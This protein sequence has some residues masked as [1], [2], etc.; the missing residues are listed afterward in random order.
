[1]TSTI[2]VDN[3]QDQDGNNIIN[4]NANTIT[5]GASGDTI[6]LASGASQTGFGREGSVNWQTGSIKTANFTAANGEG[7]FCNTSGGAFTA[8]LP[9]SPSAGDIVAFADYTRTFGTNNLTIGRNSEPIGGIAQDAKL[10]VNGQ[11]ATFV[12]VDGTEGWIN[13][14]ETQT[15]QTG[16]PPFIVA[17]GGTETTC[18]DCKIH[19][20]TGPGTF[21][22][23]N[24]AAICGPTRNIVSYMVVAGGGSGTFGG[25]GGAGGFRELKSPLT[26]YTAS[27][28]DGYSTPGN[29]IT[30]SAQGYP[31]TVG[32]GGA[33]T[34]KPSGPAGTPGNNGSNSVFSTIT[35]AGGGWGGVATPT[36]PEANSGNS[37]GSG[38]GGG[39]ERAP[40]SN[41]G[42]CGSAGNTPPV[43]PP[44]G[45]SGGKG[46]YDGPSHTAGG[47]GGGA[48]GAGSNSPGG[49]SPQ[50]IT[51]G[52]A[53]GTGVGTAINPSPS[54]GTPGPST[55]LRYFAGGGRGG[56]N[57]CSPVPEKAGSV[58]GGG[59]GG[60][61]GGNGTNGT[62]NTGGGAGGGGTFSGTNTSGGS[63][64]VI[65]R[66][67][68]Q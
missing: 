9:A 39:V 32:A 44:Q 60:I 41:K 65:I 58:G 66:Y 22:V 50:P 53:G 8:T 10:T 42:L 68:F 11:S 57:N 35:S 47:G 19:T 48:G 45:N 33:G 52:G 5:I 28:L 59:S 31:I 25:G 18:G 29:R 67:K 62:T 15:S 63:G 55:P 34:A 46:S 54:Y 38:G 49:C 27:P 37:G 56:T 64:I 43:S 4:E 20:F 6:T 26:P 17:S 12:Y 36:L 7:Y 23:C 61:G 2:K 14:Q 13:I 51:P 3:I 1:M 30:V 16:L 21:T 24:A 40:G